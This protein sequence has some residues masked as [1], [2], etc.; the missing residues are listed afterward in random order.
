[1]W[2]TVLG[3]VLGG[4][5]AFLPT[6]FLNKEAYKRDLQ[7]RKLERAIAAREV[8]LREGE[9]KVK[10]MTSVFVL[11]SKAMTL[12]VNIKTESEANA[13]F[14]TFKE[15]NKVHEQIDKGKALNHLSIKSLSDEPLTKAWEK[16]NNSYNAYF[17]FGGEIK[18]FIEKEARIFNKEEKN[19]Y[20]ERE[21]VLNQ[22][23]CSSVESFLK[24]INELRSQ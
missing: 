20:S 10:D 15:L 1:M 11:F 22:E 2:E 8:R 17:S 21:K 18:D 6:W 16:V 24:R 9:E 7:T 14:D 3:V 12:W 19:K 4:L 23:Y 13:I 5:V